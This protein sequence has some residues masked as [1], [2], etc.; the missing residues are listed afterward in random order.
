LILSIFAFVAIGLFISVFVDSESIAI[1]LSLLIVMPMLFL[2]GLILPTYFMPSAL[3]SIANVL[4][5]TLGKNALIN[6]IVG[7]SA[8][9]PGLILLGY[10]IVFLALVYVFRKR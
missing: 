8:L 1:L 6:A 2:S 5:L 10:T 9:V 4:P 7:K 3:S